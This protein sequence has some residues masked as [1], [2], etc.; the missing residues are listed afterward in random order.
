MRSLA[1]IPWHSARLPDSI[2]L[3]NIG[4]STKKVRKMAKALPTTPEHRKGRTTLAQP[5]VGTEESN[6]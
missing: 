6:E 1:S 3:T 5:T 2:D 4:A